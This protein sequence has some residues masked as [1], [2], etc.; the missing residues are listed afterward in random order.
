MLHILQTYKAFSSTRLRS[1]KWMLILTSHKT[2][3][4]KS[5]KH[6]CLLENLHPGH[7]SNKQNKSTQPPPLQ[8]IKAENRCCNILSHVPVC[9]KVGSK[10]KPALSSTGKNDEALM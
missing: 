9:R 1:I 7:A 4:P 2:A 10:Q 3:V 5:N 8:H 6:C